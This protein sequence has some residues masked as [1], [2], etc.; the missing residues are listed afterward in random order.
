MTASTPADAAGRRPLDRALDALPL[1]LGYVLLC[2]LYGWQASRHDSPTIFTDELEF[3]QISRA[4][5]ETGEAARRGSPYDA[6][7]LYSYLV[8]PAWWI[9]DTANAYEAAKFIGVLVMTATIFPAHA[10][11]RTIVSKPWALGAAVAAA[12]I[13][14]LSYAP[15]LVEEPL[16]YPVATAALWLIVR[17]VGRPTRWT[18]GLA[19]IVCAGAFLVRAQLSILIP[20]LGLALALA[21]WQ[22]PAF[23][24][25]R[26]SWTRTDYVGL[27][28][29]GLG[30][31]LALSAFLGHRSEEWYR[32]TGF[33]KERMFDYGLRALGALVIGIGV[34]PFVAGLAAVLTRG[35]DPDRNVRAFVLTALAAFFTFGLYTAV[36][37]AYIS[38][39]FG[40]VTVERNLIYVAPLLFAGT[41]LVLERPGRRFLALGGAALVALYVLLTTPYELDKYPYYDAP[42]LA[43]AALPN[44]VW[45][46][47]GERIEQALVVV[48]ILSV[49]LLVARSLVRGRRAAVLAGAVGALVVGW[50]VTAEI[51][52]AEGQNDFARRLYENAPQ[53]VDWLDR[54][55]GG[56]PALFLGAAVDDANGIHLLE[57]WNR[58][59]KQVW[60]IDGPAPGPGPTLSP[61]LAL[62]DGTLTPDPGY[63]W[64]VAEN[65]ADVVGTRVGA[66]HGSL[67]LYRLDGPLRLTSARSGVLG[68]GWMS[69]AAAFNQFATTENPR[70]YAKVVLSRVASCG[71]NKP[72]KVTVKVGTVVVG[73]KKQP[74]IGRVLH[75]RRAVLNQCKVL[76]PPKLLIP[77]TVP[78]R[79]EV[80][81]EPTFSPNELDPASSDIRELGA[82]PE[83]G[84]VPLP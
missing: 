64:V 27:A 12:A 52:A 15:F 65:D 54:A 17:A 35:R 30:A 10:L 45:R 29:L 41:A 63:R 16:A 80:T 44:R 14:A 62:P 56:E 23:R 40:T 66:P 20:V 47:E 81:I 25:R 24:R 37:A 11:A 33:Y 19:G 79:V 38:T 21:G 82:K 84:Y 76:G 55:T 34:L 36:K 59:L 75:E 6:Q 5:A 73:P 28:V 1:V 46:W 61:D 4:I 78:F 49:A 31:A 13:P 70:G 51:Y 60:S 74:S 58:S 8:A 39:E 83:F 77:A 48:L 69:S 18:I 3:A 71:P 42:G 53:P 9:D 50:N 2:C 26:A 57:F 43:I 67:Q 32:A 7:T 22:H 72:G 68:D